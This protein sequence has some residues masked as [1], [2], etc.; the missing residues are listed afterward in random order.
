M[1]S[2]AAER[3]G[4]DAGATFVNR[5]CP[6]YHLALSTFVLHFAFKVLRHDC[7][8]HHRWFWFRSQRWHCPSTAADGFNRA[9]LIACIGTVASTWIA[10]ESHTVN[11]CKL[12]SLKRRSWRNRGT[13][14]REAVATQRSICTVFSRNRAD[15]FVQ[16]RHFGAPIPSANSEGHERSHPLALVVAEHSEHGQW[17]AIVIAGCF[18]AEH[19]HCVNGGVCDSDGCIVACGFQMSLG[20][21]VNVALGLVALFDVQF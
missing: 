15:S 20:R 13:F 9:L 4:V 7:G 18:I 1:E 17:T 5:Q 19:G 12:F 14:F 11:K 10:I 21:L 2:A 6:R 3:I 8:V 16:G